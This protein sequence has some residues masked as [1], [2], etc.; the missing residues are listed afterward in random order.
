MLLKTSAVAG[1]SVVSIVVSL[2]GGAEEAIWI[3]DL[4]MTEVQAYRVLSPCFEKDMLL[5]NM[6][7][8]VTETRF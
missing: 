5:K 4:A 6:E 8:R 7:S 2:E 3:S 1:G